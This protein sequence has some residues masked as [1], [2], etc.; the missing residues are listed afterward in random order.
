V[1]Q[2]TLNDLGSE[3]QQ[4]L[5]ELGLGDA[6]VH[7]AHG[8][9]EDELVVMVDGSSLLLR[10]LARADFR[11][12]HASE[13]PVLERHEAGMV[14]ADRIAT[15]TRQTLSERGWGWLDRR[16][17]HLRLWHPG[18]RLDAP[19]RPR[20]APEAGPRARNPFTPAGIEVSLWLL[21]HP[22]EVASP[23][24][25]ARALDVSA[26]QVS[27]LLGALA[28]HALLR[29]DRR[30]L[31]PELF[32]ALVEQWRPRRYPLSSMPD[33]GALDAPELRA[34][35]WVLCDSLAG[36]VVGAP[37]VVGGE[38]P[39]DLYV[40]DEAVLSWV[41]HRYPP[42]HDHGQRAGTVAVAPTPLVCDERTRRPV[43]AGTVTGWQGD[44]VH[45]V[46]AALDLATDR[47]RGR[48]AVSQWD[49]DPSLG[50]VRVW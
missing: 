11:P 30:P 35:E 34:H 9:G 27:N 39:P 22:E 3:L 21:L 28:A 44:A 50:V 37:L 47:A 40:P 12:V 42:A 13:L 32:W 20:L 10:T 23:R 18:L 49:P 6:R 33:A 38:H 31:I 15:R 26:G 48:E 24:A 25:I 2:R 1:R 43:P 7:P 14:F 41:L 4:V 46:V 36:V 29:Q 8:D 17:G 45:P 16:R 19:V 5:V